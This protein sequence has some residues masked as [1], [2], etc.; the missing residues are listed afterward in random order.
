[1][2]YAYYQESKESAPDVISFYIVED[3]VLIREGII[4]YFDWA[5]MGARVIG[6]AADGAAALEETLRLRPDVIIS[7]VVMPHMDG[8]AMAD[9]LRQAGWDGELI[10]LSAHR[11]PDYLQRAFKYRTHDYVV[12][13][14]ENTELLAAIRRVIDRVLEKRAL[15]ARLEHG[16]EAERSAVWM[17]LLAGK[18][19]AYADIPGADAYCVL[20]THM[21]GSGR[22]NVSWDAQVLWA[23]QE[24]DGECV[25]VLGLDGDDPDA[26]ADDIAARLRA[27]SGME[28]VARG[29]VVHAPGEL[30]ASLRSAADAL[31]RQGLPAP[32]DQE[33]YRHSEWVDRLVAVLLRDAQGLT[34]HALDW[35]TAAASAGD[36]FADMKSICAIFCA[37]LA[38][39]LSD[40]TTK[41]VIWSVLRTASAA[42]AD[43]RAAEPLRDTALAFIAELSDVLQ[44]QTR[45]ALAGYRLEALIREHPQEA[46]IDWLSERMDMSRSNLIR[47]V[48]RVRN[49][50]VNDF[51]TSIR[52]R[53]AT[54]LLG[55]TAL[56]VYEVA[57]RVGYR[58]IKHFSQLFRRETGMLPGAFRGR[59]RQK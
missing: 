27:K 12:K 6:G 13:P 49:Q 37:A 25:L 42:I 1:M 8:L 5:S 22:P 38:E 45:D 26:Q 3:E 43:A 11:D 15:R 24:A 52:M 44:N 28:R 41:N 33:P 14:I 7:D 31:A 34:G 50:S 47:L 46:G 30:A 29:A 9:A 40:A 57:E 39:R 48:R 21:V 16:T 10:Y 4:H 58:D 36:S 32:A 54:E 23:Q 2:M 59:D 17:R 55:D 20:L 53:I 19:T 51:I 35:W 18:P 56:R